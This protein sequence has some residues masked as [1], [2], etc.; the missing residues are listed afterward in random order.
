MTLISPQMILSGKIP[1]K[2]VPQNGRRISVEFQFDSCWFTSALT[3]AQHKRGLEIKH[4][5]YF[6]HRN[7]ADCVCKA[8]GACTAATVHAD[9]WRHWATW[10]SPFRRTLPWSANDAIERPIHHAIVT[11]PPGVEPS[12]NTASAMDTRSMLVYECDRTQ[13]C[14]A[15]RSLVRH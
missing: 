12:V 9:A 8:S 7:L 10:P 3:G 5:C 15:C 4:Y 6:G 2:M 14:N 1:I 13:V 11:G